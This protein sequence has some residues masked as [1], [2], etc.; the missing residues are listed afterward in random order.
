MYHN[1]WWLSVTLCLLYSTCLHLVSAIFVFGPGA[2][3]SFMSYPIKVF[4]SQVST[5]KNE[6]LVSK[7]SHIR[8]LKTLSVLSKKLLLHECNRIYNI[9]NVKTHI[10]RTKTSI[11][12]VCIERLYWGQIFFFFHLENFEFGLVRWRTNFMKS[13][14]GDQKSSLW[15]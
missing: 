4:T 10:W 15:F 5:Y 7:K 12:V 14:K 8:T 9:I 1:S 13:P 6:I 11:K 2:T 3:P